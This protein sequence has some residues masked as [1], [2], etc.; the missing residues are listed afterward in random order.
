[1]IDSLESL[2]EELAI[3][4]IGA[5]VQRKLKISLESKNN[6]LAFVIFMREYN[7]DL[8]KS[9]GFPFAPAAKIALSDKISET[10]MKRYIT[11]HYQTDRVDAV[12]DVFKPTTKL[13]WF[14][15]ILSKNAKVNRISNQTEWIS[16]P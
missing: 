9:F 12:I 14:E 4:R 1:M 10:E 16:P 2:S 6:N 13:A 8:L 11:T 7:K 15:K 5:E 3:K